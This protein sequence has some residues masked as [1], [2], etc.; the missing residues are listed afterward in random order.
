MGH[1][2]SPYDH[3]HYTPFPA[4]LPVSGEAPTPDAAVTP[5]PWEGNL[6]CS[7]YW[8]YPYASS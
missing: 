4:H 8:F 1:E 6:S 2:E 5:S 3:W 7:L